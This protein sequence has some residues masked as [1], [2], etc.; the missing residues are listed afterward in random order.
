MSTRDDVEE[1]DESTRMKDLENS[2]EEYQ[3]TPKKTSTPR[4]EKGG[5]ALQVSDDFGNLSLNEFE[6]HL[7]SMR[8]SYLQKS[9]RSKDEVNLTADLMPRDGVR[10]EGELKSLGAIAATS[11]KSVE[12]A[13]ELKGVSP[14]SVG[15]DPKGKDTIEDGASVISNSN[16]SGFEGF[17]SGDEK[18][19]IDNKRKE[20]GRYQDLVDKMNN[21]KNANDFITKVIDTNV[22]EEGKRK[23]VWEDNPLRKRKKTFAEAAKDGFMVEVRVLEQ[24]YLVSREDF[25]WIDA[26][27][28]DIY[29]DDD[30]AD[31]EFEAIQAGISQ[32]CLWWSCKNMES[33]IYFQENL[34]T[35][36]AQP[37]KPT[38]TFK[39]YGPGERPYRYFRAKVGA[40]IWR[41]AA[42]FVRRIRK[43]NRHLKVDGR[44]LH[45]RVVN[46]CQDKQ[47][48]IKGD[49]FWVRLEIEE[50]LFSRIL[51]R[52][53]EIRL[54]IAT[55]TFLTG[56]GMEKGMV[57]RGWWTEREMV[58]KVSERFGLEENDQRNENAGK[59][60]TAQDKDINVSDA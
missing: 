27:L 46:G 30:S 51:D 58:K 38:A 13:K 3:E 21:K 26:K 53:G 20:V 19:Y 23:A 56:G 11:A 14:G 40:L 50:E 31:F 49:V 9:R 42:D 60:I 25:K 48:E 43:F 2:R 28:S 35:V 39:A 29:V 5:L 52:K 32:N 1:V 12:V 16:S 37:D 22:V 15:I 45:I 57:E 33:L 4:I 24:D 10:Y 6:E 34:P 36:P 44:D 47:K 17:D 59:E 7:N 54:G 41:P 55:C 18:S 8:R